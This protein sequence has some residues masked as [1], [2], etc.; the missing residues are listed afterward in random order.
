MEQR[1]KLFRLRQVAL[2][3]MAQALLLRGRRIRSGDA[4]D[5]EPLLVQLCRYGQT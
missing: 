3:A 2:V 4:R 1:L 5:I